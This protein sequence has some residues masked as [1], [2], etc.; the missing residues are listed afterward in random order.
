M[1]LARRRFLHLLAGAAAVPVASRAQ[2]YPARP[3]L[4]IAGFAAGGG[5]D[6]S[7]HL[8]AQ[9]LSEQLGQPFSVENRPGANSNKATEAVVRAPPD[10]YTLLL[11]N[12]ANAINSALYDKLSFN[13]IRDIAPVAGIIRLPL[14]MLVN[15]SVPAQTVPEFIAYAKANPGKVNMASAGTGT[16]NTS[17]ASCSS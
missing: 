10:G 1:K 8:I 11:I 12:P 14:V 16:P 13:F 5:V 2:T 9:R 4:I 3:V 15:R 7:A 17:P 6:I